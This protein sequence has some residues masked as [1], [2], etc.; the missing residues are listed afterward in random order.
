MQLEMPP[1]VARFFPESSLG[2]VGTL[3]GALY[4]FHL[5]AAG[6]LTSDRFLA[7]RLSLEIKHSIPVHTAPLRSLAL[8]HT[9]SSNWAVTASSDRSLIT[10]DC[11]S[12]DGTLRVANA[13]KS[14]VNALERRPD[15]T[16]FCSGDDDGNLKARM[17][18][19]L[20]VCYYTRLCLLISQRALCG[21]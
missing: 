9:S 6:E 19:L 18:S 16:T 20:I 5:G 15:D 14:K 4:L 3:S 11:N 10:L 7:P 2:A 1:L 21:S 13:H 12:L 17:P 8:P